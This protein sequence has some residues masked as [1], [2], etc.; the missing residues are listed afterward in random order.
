MNVEFSNLNVY[1]S[2]F[3]PVC[4]LEEPPKDSLDK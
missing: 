3:F 4:H 1:I 2:K